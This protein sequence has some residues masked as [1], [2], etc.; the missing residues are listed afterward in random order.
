MIPTWY[1]LDMKNLVL[2]LAICA[3]FVAGILLRDARIIRRGR[4]MEH[5]HVEL[6]EGSGGVPDHLPPPDSSIPS[7]TIVSKASVEANPIRAEFTVLG[8]VKPLLERFAAYR[9]AAPV[10]LDPTACA[11]LRC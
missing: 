1:G 8:F 11:I 6:L 4:R 5:S 10:S 9:W 3:A 2:I 7:A